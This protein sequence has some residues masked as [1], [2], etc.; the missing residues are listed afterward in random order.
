MRAHTCTHAHTLVR[1]HCGRRRRQRRR[2]NNAAAGFTNRAHVNSLGRPPMPPSPQLRAHA[3]QYHALHLSRVR[4]ERPTASL[5]VVVAALCAR[6]RLLS[7]ESA[8]GQPL[9]AV[10]LAG[11]RSCQEAQ[12]SR[13]VMLLLRLKHCFE[14]CTRVRIK[15]IGTCEWCAKVRLRAPAEA[16]KRRAAS[17]AR[18]G[19]CGRCRTHAQLTDGSCT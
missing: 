15:P 8:R 17:R 5:T 16:A 1:G 3:Q 14:E 11:A 2:C 12:A 18:C 13:V 19:S 7:R 10:E 6:R 4:A 9:R